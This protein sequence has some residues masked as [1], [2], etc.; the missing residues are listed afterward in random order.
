M[1]GET[2]LH[3]QNKGLLTLLPEIQQVTHRCSGKKQNCDLQYVPGEKTPPSNTIQAS[4]N[5]F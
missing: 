5:Q 2:L 1:N 4:D 3:G